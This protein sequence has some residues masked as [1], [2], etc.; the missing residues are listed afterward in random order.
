MKKFYSIFLLMMLPLFAMGESYVLTV[1]NPENLSYTLTYDPNGGVNLAAIQGGVS[2]KLRVTTPSSKILN[3]VTL[4]GQTLELSGP[5]WNQFYYFN[6]PMSDATLVIDAVDKSQAIDEIGV[7]NGSEDVRY[8][9]I[10]GVQVDE[11]N[12]VPGLYIVKTGTETKKVII[13]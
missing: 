3:R 13:K 7:D 8:Y 9:N 12:L 11:Q 1:V 2:L 5:I 4:D 6:M 10:S